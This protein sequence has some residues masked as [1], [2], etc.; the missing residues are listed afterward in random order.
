[1]KLLSAL[2]GLCKRAADK[3]S[4]SFSLPWRPLWREILDIVQRQDRHLAEASEHILSE[5]L[6]ALVGFLHRY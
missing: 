4:V 3:P 5:L 1:V 2:K 6:T